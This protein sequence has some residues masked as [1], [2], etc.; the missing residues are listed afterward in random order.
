MGRAPCC[1]LPRSTRL[2]LFSILYRTHIRRVYGGWNHHTRTP[3]DISRYYDCTIQ[4]VTAKGYRVIFPAYGNVEEV[5]LEYLQKKVTVS[6]AKVRGN[7]HARREVRAAPPRPFLSSGTPCSG[8]RVG[9]SRMQSRVDLVESSN[10]PRPR[11]ARNVQEF[12][13][14]LG[15]G[16]TVVLRGS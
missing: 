1:V 15:K 6:S 2:T 11:P 7:K 16:C 12:S 8:T 13:L 4:E 5:P 14:A 10:P 9:G 3:F